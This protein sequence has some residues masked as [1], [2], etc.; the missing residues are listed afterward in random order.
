MISLTNFQNQRKIFKQVWNE[1]KIAKRSRISCFV[2]PFL[3][4]TIVMVFKVEFNPTTA[5]PP[6]VIF[7]AIILLSACFGGARA[8]LFATILSFFSALSL[9]FLPI[10]LSLRVIETHVLEAL[11]FCIEALFLSYLIWSFQTQR[12]KNKDN[13]LMVK[14]ANLLLQARE[15]D[16]ENFVHMAAHELKSPVTVLKGYHQ[17]IMARLIANQQTEEVS[18]LKKMD[19]QLDKLLHRIGDLLDLAKVNSAAMKYYQTDFSLMPCLIETVE[20]I[21]AANPYFSIEQ[22]FTTANVIINGDKE[23]IQQVIINFLNNAIKYSKAEKFIKVQ[24]VLSK[25]E[26]IVKVID[27]GIG[28]PEEKQPY[29]FD[30]FYRVDNHA[31]ISKPGLGLGLFICKEIILQHYGKIGVESKD[32]LGATFWFS[33]PLKM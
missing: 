32:G 24:T 30:R 27:H 2:L 16:H 25:D 28:V 19:Q 26:I 9:L 10:N 8:A 11:V 1:E 33:L 15:K 31:T 14:E 5:I 23:R 20:D 13:N 29:V 7:F 21:K 17:M 4:I 12:K 22:D 18:L 6:Y 3:L